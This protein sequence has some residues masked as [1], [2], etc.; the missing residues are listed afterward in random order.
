MPP[1]APKCAAHHQL[2]AHSAP[3]REIEND[4]AIGLIAVARTIEV[5]DMNC[6][7]AELAIAFEYG[8]GFFRIDGFR[9]EIAFEESDAASF[10]QDRLRESIPCV[11][12]HT[13]AENS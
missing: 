5:N 13:V 1:H 9:G 10:A 4:F 11:E 2:A 6:A 3:A 8:R 12:C 7:C